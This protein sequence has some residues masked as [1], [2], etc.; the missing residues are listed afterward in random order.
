MAA[1]D[2]L[3]T[4]D[5]QPEPAAPPARL[6]SRMAERAETAGRY[7]VFSLGGSD[8]ALPLSSVVE[9]SQALVTT[10]VPHLPAWVSGVANLRGDILAVLELAGCLEIP[11]TLATPTMVE[12]KE[13]RLLIVR[14]R[15]GEITAGLAVDAVH[16][17]SA[18]A[19]IRPAAGAAGAAGELPG[20]GASCRAGVAERDGK[21]VALLD[22]EA[23]FEIPELRRLRES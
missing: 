11:A 22:L 7:V 23:I 18:L 8:F 20:R 16:G 19:E 5:G 2:D 6:D 12:A 15:S 13:A 10:R 9:I 21:P 17:I 3:S 4:P 1:D 14:S